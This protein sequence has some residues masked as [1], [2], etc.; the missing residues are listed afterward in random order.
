MSWLSGYLRPEARSSARPAPGP[1]REACHP[2]RKVAV[3]ELPALS[4]NTA[5][6]MILA[7]AL[8]RLQL[9]PPWPVHKRRVVP[10]A[11]A[12]SDAMALS[13]R[14]A[15]LNLL[16]CNANGFSVCAQ[17]RI[18]AIKCITT[19]AA[20]RASSSPD[21]V[22]TRDPVRQCPHG[23]RF[24]AVHHKSCPAFGRHA[25]Q[26]SA[27]SHPPL[28]AAKIF[29]Q[30]SSLTWKS[31]ISGAHAFRAKTDQT[32]TRNGG[33]EASGIGAALPSRASTRRQCW[34]TERVSR[35]AS[36]PRPREPH[37]RQHMRVSSN[38]ARTR[39]NHRNR[40]TRGIEQEDQMNRPVQPREGENGVPR[41]SRRCPI[42]EGMNPHPQHAV[43]LVYGRTPASG[44]RG[45]P[46]S[47]QHRGGKPARST[48]SE[49]PQQQAHRPP[50][51]PRSYAADTLSAAAP[52][53][54]EVTRKLPSVAQHRGARHARLPARAE[55]RTGNKY[56]PRCSPIGKR[57]A[58]HDP[59]RRLNSPQ[60]RDRAERTQRH[61]DWH[62]TSPAPEH[63]RHSAASNRGV[64]L[65]LSTKTPA[66]S[67]RRR[68]AAY[69]PLEAEIDRSVPRCSQPSSWPIVS[70]QGRGDPL[71][72][73]FKALARDL[74]LPRSV[75]ELARPRRAAA[76][77]GSA[78][79]HPSNSS[80]RCSRIA[81]RES[82]SPRSKQVEEPENA[83]L[84]VPPGKDKICGP[85]VCAAIFAGSGPQLPELLQR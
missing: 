22:S 32:T 79:P 57:R 53:T 73:R 70:G 64:V 12:Q 76:T 30:Q 33:R 2:T 1:S 10:V 36:Q 62:H 3:S 41:Q 71:P 55:L 46:K 75:E 69:N 14:A 68:L 81:V 60:Q 16:G 65:T 6:T 43:G 49:T 56:H 78:V 19:F 58:P 45:A 67:P 61:I 28:I 24:R 51:G 80:S 17:H 47:F 15:N 8:A 74:T 85:A 44:D 77:R 50:T 52:E 35:S 82:A 13:S 18:L 72:R 11:T 23:I 40:N 66:R 7:H 63:A 25:Q 5:H 84:N 48:A 54:A 31:R 34:V 21:C 39:G 29:T 42:S 83:I 20:R 9:A 37:R 27:E 4:A 59:T 26:P 38:P